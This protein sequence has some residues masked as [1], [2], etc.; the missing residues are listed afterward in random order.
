MEHVQYTLNTKS[1]C[2]NTDVLIILQRNLTWQITL[3]WTRARLLVCISEPASGDI[4]SKHEVKQDIWY[5]I[6]ITDFLCAAVVKL[7]YINVVHKER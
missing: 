3:V 1:F 7:I 6:I 4:L 5:G 2:K